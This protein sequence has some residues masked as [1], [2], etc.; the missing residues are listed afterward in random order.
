MID[1]K[2]LLCFLALFLLKRE[3][4]P[5]GGNDHSG[6]AFSSETSWESAYRETRVTG[7][8]ARGT[9]GRRKEGRPFYP[10]HLPLRANFL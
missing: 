10:S 2:I 3:K 8:E 4:S 6:T 9:M 5:S 1:Q 7:D